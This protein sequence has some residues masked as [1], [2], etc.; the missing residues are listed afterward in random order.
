MRVVMWC[1]RSHNDPNTYRFP[2]KSELHGFILDEFANND[3][4]NPVDELWGEL[5][6]GRRIELTAEWFV[7]AMP[8]IPVQPVGERSE[9]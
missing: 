3:G 9:E 6:D 4:M 7:V 5:E 2:N 1:L 8:A